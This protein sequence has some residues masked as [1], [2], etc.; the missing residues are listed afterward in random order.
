MKPLRRAFAGLE[1]RPWPLA[2]FAGLGFTLLVAGATALLGSAELLDAL[3]ALGDAKLYG[4]LAFLF[5]A[6]ACAARIAFR[7][8]RRL[9]EDLDEIVLAAAPPK[10][11]GGRS[12]PPE[13]A[14]SDKPAKAYLR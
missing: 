7:R 13:V 6:S 11:A 14:P 10:Q 9:E 2:I 12:V 1:R 8:R 3:V 4:A 5:A